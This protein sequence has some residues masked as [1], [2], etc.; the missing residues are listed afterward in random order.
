MKKRMLIGMF[1][2]AMILF[3]ACS[4][5]PDNGGLSG[6]QADS[7]ESEDSASDIPPEERDDLGAVETQTSLHRNFR[8]VRPADWSEFEAGPS[9]Y[10]YTPQDS[11]PTDP[12]SEKITVVVSSLPEGSEVSYQ[13]LIDQGIEASK[14]EMPDI[15]L[16]EETENIS[17]GGREGRLARFR[18]TL[19]NSMMEFNQAFIMEGSRLYTLT[20]TCPEDSCDNYNV[21]NVMR[22]SMEIYDAE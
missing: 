4:S 14:E 5:W 19:K 21:F 17:I 18:G 3:T 11:N 16:I 1:L 12:F 10:L 22:N 8:L 9:S 15:K 7:G 20:Y 6:D 2:A 13:Q